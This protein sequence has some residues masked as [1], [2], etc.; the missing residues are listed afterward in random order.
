M[1]EQ[2]CYL[3]DFATRNLMEMSESDLIAEYRRSGSEE[4][5]AGLVRQ[6]GS[7]VFS[8]AR[9]RVGSAALA[10]EVAQTVFLRL[11]QKAPDLKDSAAVTG[12]PHRS[13]AAVGCIPDLFL[14]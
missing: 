12:W 2:V 10:E 14:S 13:Q 9:R 6:H 1:F 5:F 3:F 8:V 7:L 4:A 11:A